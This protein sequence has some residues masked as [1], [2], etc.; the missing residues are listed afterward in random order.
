[1]AYMNIGALPV[2]KAGVSK[3]AAQSAASASVL[4]KAQLLTSTKSDLLQ[5]RANLERQRNLR[6]GLIV[7]GALGVAGYV[8]SRS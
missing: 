3:Q 5:A 7:L 4:P 8:W 1:M 6:L 2:D